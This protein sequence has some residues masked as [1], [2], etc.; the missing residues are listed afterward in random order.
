MIVKCLTC[1]KDLEYDQHDLVM[2]G[3]FIQISFHY[4]SKHDQCKGFRG[5]NSEDTE[6]NKL[7]GC[8]EIEAYICDEC[9]EKK[10]PLMKGFNVKVKRDRVQKV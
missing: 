1:E 8:D 9:F 3:G 2:N 4:G 6:L 10:S 7:L 5:N